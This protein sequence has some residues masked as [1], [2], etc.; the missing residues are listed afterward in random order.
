MAGNDKSGNN[1]RIAYVGSRIQSKN[2]KTGLWPK[3]ET[4][5]GQFMD[6]KISSGRF[7]VVRKEKQNEI[8]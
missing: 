4:Q 2:S 8:Y 6:V 5:T 1:W 3:S 7:I